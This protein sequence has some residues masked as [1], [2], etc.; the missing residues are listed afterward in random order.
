MAKNTRET[1]ETRMSWK[2]SP[3]ALD[4]RPH[5]FV[6]RERSH[7]ESAGIK[8]RVKEKKESKRKKGIR[9]ANIKNAQ[10]E[11]RKKN[12]RPNELGEKVKHCRRTKL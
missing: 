9:S 7:D 10:E 5:G 11:N 3:W 4:S 8:C 12:G 6:L 1:E 2:A